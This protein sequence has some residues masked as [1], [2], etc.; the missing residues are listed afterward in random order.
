M[1]P[2]HTGPNCLKAIFPVLLLCVLPVAARAQGTAQ[3]TGSAAPAKPPFAILDNSFLVEEAFNQEAGIFQNIFGFQRNG[4][5]WDFAFTQEWPIRSQTHQ[6]SYTLP[7]AG[8]PGERGLGEVMINYRFQATL[9]DGRTPAFSPRLSLILPTASSAATENGLGVQVNLPASK[10]FGNV[11][12]HANTGFTWF[13]R[14]E[15]QPLSSNSPRA[16]LVS[17]HVAGSAIYRVRQMFNLMVESVLDFE[18]SFGATGMKGREV[19]FTL[20]PGARG[21]WNIGDHQL[22]LGAAVPITWVASDSSAGIL[23]YLS[24][25]L[26]FKR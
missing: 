4:K 18:E 14:A 8:A 11:Y 25:E 9:E 7:Y 13:P 12:F 15:T 17:P 1:L 23:L 2:S 24:Y 20:S 26:P 16:S 10:Q 19:T 5:A 22:I 3:T 21:G 6:F